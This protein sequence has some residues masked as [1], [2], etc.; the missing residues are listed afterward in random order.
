[1]M[2]SKKSIFIVVLFT[3]ALAGCSSLHFPW[4]Y[5]IDIPQGNFVTDDMVA[6][7][8]PG[9]TPAQVRFVMGPPMLI[10]PFTKDTWFYLMTYRPGDAE[11][12]HQR[13]VVYFNKGLYDH[14]TGQVIDDFKQRTQGQKDR[15]LEHKAE[16]QADMADK[17][18]NS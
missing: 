6:Q 12:V 16:R 8:E 1:M 13:I 15:E 18:G 7:L 4:V 3:L 9:M 10:D 5:R 17:V 14:Y 2:M 11:T